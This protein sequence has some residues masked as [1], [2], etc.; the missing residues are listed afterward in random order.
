[1]SDEWFFTTEVRIPEEFTE[2]LDISLNHQKLQSV[3]TFVL[4]ML[5]RHENGIKVLVEKQNNFNPEIKSLNASQMETS[6][7]LKALD[8]TIAS[9][10]EVMKS[11]NDKLDTRYDT[12]ETLKFLL[13]LI[14]SHDSLITTQKVKIEEIQ[15]EN[16]ALITKITDIENKFKDI[17]IKIDLRASVKDKITTFNNH[18]EEKGTSKQGNYLQRGIDNVESLLS[19]GKLLDTDHSNRSRTPAS[20]NLHKIENNKLSPE[21]GQKKVSE[22]NKQTGNLEINSKKEAHHLKSKESELPIQ[23]KLN[24]Y[25]G[26]FPYPNKHYTETEKLS[27]K[28]LEVSEEIQTSKKNT[29]VLSSHIKDLQSRLDTIEKI[30]GSSEPSYLQHRLHHFEDTLKVIEPEILKSKG[31]IRVLTKKITDMEGDIMN[32]LNTEHFDAVKSLVFSI[33]SGLSRMDVPAVNLLP[34]NDLNFLENLNKRISALETSFIDNKISTSSID[35]ISLKLHRIEKKLDFKVESAE[36]DKIRHS[37]TQIS[38]Q[39]KFISSELEDKKHKL[40]G[41]KPSDSALITSINRKFLSFDETIKSLMLPQGVTIPGMFEEMQ[42]L[43]DAVKFILSSLEA[44]SN[45]YDL[46][47]NDLLERSSDVLLEKYVKQVES[48]L[49]EQF[50]ALTDKYEKRFADKFEMLRGF[51]YVENEMNRLERMTDKVEGDE[52]MLAK[53]P[54]GGWSCASCEKNIDKLASKTS[55]YTPWNKLPIRDPKERILKA[56][57]GYSK[58]LC[59]LPLEPLKKKRSHYQDE[60]NLPPVILTD[61]S[62]TPQPNH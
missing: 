25:E 47:I 46:K 54:L 44:Y 39:N 18:A 48:G 12:A 4:D 45:Q 20:I 5:K 16:E 51:K 62:I 28:P 61:R 43:W 29:M 8:E 3:M 34:S 22:M 13:N 40:A 41:L 55:M 50:K 21:P 49:R 11:V 33:A 52:A 6:E 35:D 56:G 36:I 2:L 57:S 60:L 1:M 42:K 9:T 27:P 31:N 23:K 26:I 24:L 59:T 58:M 38:D 17:Y 53:K 14:S 7:K 37:L 30:V 32:K 15:K 10:S 19:L